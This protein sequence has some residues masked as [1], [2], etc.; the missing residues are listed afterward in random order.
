[1]SKAK[2]KAKKPVKYDVWARFDDGQILRVNGTPR[3]KA[4]AQADIDSPTLQEIYE[5]AKLYMST[6]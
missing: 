2:A 1:M 5:D 3:T 6:R 4:Q